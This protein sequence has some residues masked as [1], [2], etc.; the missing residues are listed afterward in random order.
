MAFTWYPPEIGEG[1]HIVLVPLVFLS[2]SGLAWGKTTMLTLQAGQ[3]KQD[4]NNGHQLE[5]GSY[6]NLYQC[7]S[8][9]GSEEFLYVV[10]L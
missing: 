1:M 2:L 5:Q 4:K 3:R 6:G 10:Q 8:V 7:T 9:C